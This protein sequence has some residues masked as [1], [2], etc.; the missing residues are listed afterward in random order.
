MSL[1][2]LQQGAAKRMV[3]KK[4]LGWPSVCLSCQRA[5]EA[6]LTGMEF[7]H[8]ADCGEALFWSKKKVTNKT[9]LRPT[10]LSSRTSA[11]YFV[12]LRMEIPLLFQANLLMHQIQG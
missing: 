1:S 7:N 5:L 11:P 3:Q 9:T 10:H 2:G 8:S 4:E 6:S 12:W